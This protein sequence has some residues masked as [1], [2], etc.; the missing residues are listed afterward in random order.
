M[1][2]KG[3]DP[4]ELDATDNRLTAKMQEAIRAGKVGDKVYFE[5]IKGSMPDGSKPTLSAVGFVLN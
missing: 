2:P 3:K 1:Y 4:V 5:Y